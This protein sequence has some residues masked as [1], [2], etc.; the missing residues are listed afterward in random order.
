MTRWADHVGYPIELRWMVGM[1]S[2]RWMGAREV[3]YLFMYMFLVG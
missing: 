3:V 2:V 1:V